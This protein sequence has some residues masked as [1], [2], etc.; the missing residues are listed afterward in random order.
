MHWSERQVEIL[1]S[2]NS[3]AYKPGACSYKLGSIFSPFQR[4][5]LLTGWQPELFAALLCLAG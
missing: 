3:K 2:L 5:W 1:R 4:R